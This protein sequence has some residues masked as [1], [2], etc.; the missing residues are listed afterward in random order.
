MKRSNPISSIFGIILTVLLFVG[1][2]LS[3]WINRGLAFSPGPITAIKQA[4]ITLGGYSS[5]AD[6]E[7]QC[8]NCHQPLKTDLASQCFTCHE[9]I[10]QQINGGEGLHSA[11]QASK[12]CSTCHPDH[13]G[14]D[15]NPTLASYQLFDHSAAGFSLN[16]HQENYDATPMLCSECHQSA[17]FSDMTNQT[18]IDCHGDHDPD[19]ILTHHQDYGPNCLQCHDGSDR[20]LNFDHNQTSFSLSGRHE[21]ILCTDCHVNTQIN[22]TPSECK[23]CHGEPSIH[24]GLFDQAC[25]GCHSASSWTEAKLDNQP[26]THFESAGFSLTLHQRDYADQTITCLTC[27]P[28]NLQTTDLK[29]CIE[30]HEQ[31]DKT[32]M[33]DHQQ[34]FGSDCMVCHDGIDRLSNY[35][36]VNFFPL[37]G[38]HA[39]SECTDCH[40]D[41]TYRGTASECWQCHQEPDI[42]AGVFGDSC[43]DCHTAEAW[44][45]ATL[46]KH[47]FP[48]NHGLDDQSLQLQCDGCHTT[49]YIDYTCYNCHEHQPDEMTKTHLSQG[50]SEQDIP[51]CVNCHPSGTD[52]NS[53]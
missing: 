16:W 30:C 53:Q 11:I 3:L 2:G 52:A 15:F 28:E 17:D 48:L 45:P 4:N 41:N 37:D 44:S 6:F 20:M 24:Q 27:H 38:K 18:C 33:S 7:K 21:Q 47:E 12:D 50:I 32:F 10:N 1:L 9:E 39:S 51:Q 34:Q 31:H 22:D 40:T 19:F 26:F 36:H 5:H 29:Q 42:H 25:E 49:N 46:L 43:D 13:R 35:E 8:G 14:R 23:D